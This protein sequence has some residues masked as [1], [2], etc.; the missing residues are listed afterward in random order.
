MGTHSFSRQLEGLGSVTAST[1]SH[2]AGL[3]STLEAA[4]VSPPATVKP[5][6]ER[7][8]APENRSWSS[9]LSNRSL[10]ALRHTWG[11]QSVER[12]TLDFGSGRDLAV[13]GIESRVGLCTDGTE[14]AWDSLSLFTLCPSPACARMLSISLCLSE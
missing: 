14:T 8:P 11:A 6:W 13:H 5:R 1:P 2:E 3:D 4:G 10:E 12:L 7:S 9:S